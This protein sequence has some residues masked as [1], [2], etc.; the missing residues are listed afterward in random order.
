[1]PGLSEETVELAARGVEGALL[2]FPAVVDERAA[3]LVD[4]IAD[5]LFGGNLPQARFF[6]HVA[7]D[8][9]A[10][11]PHI[12]DV[13]L[14]GSFRQAGA[15]EVQEEGHEVCDESSARWEVLFP[16]HPTLRPLLKI[17]AVA[18]VWQ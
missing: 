12:V 4:H 6:V 5:K 11:Q 16:T 14:N 3:V 17:A 8:L 18:A 7:N 15:G 10:E 9:S 1:M 13:V 2:V